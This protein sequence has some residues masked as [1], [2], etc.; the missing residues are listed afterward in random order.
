[1][2]RRDDVDSATAE[3]IGRDPGVLA[4]E[5]RLADLRA[6]RATVQGQILAA[7]AARSWPR[8]PLRAK[9]AA[10]V[11]GEPAAPEQRD[12]GALV[13]RAEVLDEAIRMAEQA[14]LDARREAGR[15][16]AEAMTPEHDAILG[17]ISAALGAL[18][19]ALSREWRLH[20]SLRAEGACPSWPRPFGGEFGILKVLRTLDVD[21]WRAFAAGEVL[22]LGASGSKRGEE[23]W[24]I[25]YR[26]AAS[27][28]VE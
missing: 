21:G 17:D 1:M 23:E 24:E 13:R 20:E 19:D 6:E 14:V 2:R 3:A 11:A 8:D 10:L 25:T 9:A 12:F 16:V 15:R 22:F 18:V 5:S 26:F 28:N 27:P 4:A 7:D